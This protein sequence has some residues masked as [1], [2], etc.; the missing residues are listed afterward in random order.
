MEAKFTLKY[1]KPIPTI[2]P[3]PQNETFICLTWNHNGT[4]VNSINPQ[5]Y[6]YYLHGIGYYDMN[7][8]LAANINEWKDFIADDFTRNGSFGY[9]YISQLTRSTKWAKRYAS[10]WENATPIDPNEP[11]TIE[12]LKRARP[13]YRLLGKGTFR[14]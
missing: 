8:S 2:V 11:L 7:N 10:M 9:K 6:G 14:I 1:H 3:G 13:N 5:L 12:S 4:F